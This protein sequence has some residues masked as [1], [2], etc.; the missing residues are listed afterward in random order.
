MVPS[1]FASD[2]NHFAADGQS[3]GDDGR[4]ARSAGA[5]SD[6]PLDTVNWTNALAKMDIPNSESFGAWI[7]AI[8]SGDLPAPHDHELAEIFSED[9]SQIGFDSDE[10]VVL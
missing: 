6:L 5:G 9:D 1:D 4:Y 7:D 2:R 8:S 10:Q 3:V